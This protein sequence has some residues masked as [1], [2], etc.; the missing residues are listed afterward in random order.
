MPPIG[1]QFRITFKTV[2]PKKRR[3]NLL[4]LWKLGKMSSGQMDASMKTGA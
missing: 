1:N 4:Q 3:K 2:E